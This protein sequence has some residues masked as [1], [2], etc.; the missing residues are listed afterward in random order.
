M[1]KEQIKGHLA[2]ITSNVIFGLNITVTKSLLSAWMSP[3][4]Y[5][6][7]RMIFGVIVFWLIAL[8]R[9]NE[10]VNRKDL[11]F[12][13]ICA[14]LGIV[15]YQGAF[16]IGIGFVTP[17]LWS[18]IMALNPVVILLLSALLLKEAMT[19]KKVFG[20]IIGI[21]G[22][23]LIINKTG[24]GGVSSNIVLGICLAFFGVISNGLYI[25]I[26]RK[27]SAKYETITIMKWMFLFSAIIISPFGIRELP[28]QRLYSQEISIIPILQLGFALFF[29]SLLAF[30]L[31]P[32]SLKRI[33]ATVASVYIN[34]QPIVASVVAIIVGQDIFSW[35]KP[36]ALI[37]VI[38]SV[39]IVTQEPKNK[40]LK[41]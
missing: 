7:T 25:V 26:T 19:I 11:V 22:V 15:F 4:G 14:L 38:L 24:D 1:D 8:V 10:K 27:T 17:V 41:Q 37:L 29:S 32:V 40:M 3:M 2:A 20:V 39:L 18:L 9:G 36:L 30:F 5:T 31:I 33:K 16:S 6:M 12:F 21:A 23:V 35:D 28:A 13:L 34:L